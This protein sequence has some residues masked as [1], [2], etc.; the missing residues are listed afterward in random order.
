MFFLTLSTLKSELQL[1]NFYQAEIFLIYY[2]GCFK[3]NTPKSSRD[4]LKT[5][6]NKKTLA[7]TKVMDIP[8][9]FISCFT[10]AQCGHQ[11]QQFI[12]NKNV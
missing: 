8:S 5:K 1:K 11:Q 10:S 12:V 7:W 6:N 3:K 9:S 4:M 2:T